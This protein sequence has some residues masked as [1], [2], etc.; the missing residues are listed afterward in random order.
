MI[1]RVEGPAIVEREGLLPTCRG[2][3]DVLPVKAHLGRPPG[4]EVVTFE[5]AIAAP[6][7]TDN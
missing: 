2:L 6:E 7:P 3:C 1:L 5:P 4:Q